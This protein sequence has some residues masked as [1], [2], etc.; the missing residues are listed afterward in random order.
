M[1]QNPLVS[2]ASG[3]EYVFAHIF[4]YLIVHDYDDRRVTGHSGCHMRMSTIAL[5]RS[6]AAVNDKCY[7]RVGHNDHVVLNRLIAESGLQADGLVLDARRHE[8]HKIPRRYAHTRVRDRPGASN[9]GAPHR[10]I[11]QVIPLTAREPRGR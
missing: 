7:L 1:H 6:R 10:V 2:G 3:F 4:D 5:A 11:T 9:A 8:R